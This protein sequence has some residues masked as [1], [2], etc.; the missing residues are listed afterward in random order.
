MLLIG[1]LNKHV[2]ADEEGIE[3]NNVRISYGGELLRK[4]LSERNFSMLNR[5]ALTKGGP[6]TRVDPADPSKKSCLDYALVSSELLPFIDEVIIDSQKTFTPKRIINN[7]KDVSTD[8]FSYIIHFKN[9]PLANKASK[10]EEVNYMKY[11]EDWGLE[12][13]QRTHEYLQ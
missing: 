10:K 12:K 11:K 3:G 5:L 4:F 2:G 9:L 1:D 6:F 13:V 8:H 7:G